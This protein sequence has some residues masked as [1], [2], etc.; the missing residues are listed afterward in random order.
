M[1]RITYLMF[2]TVMVVTLFFVMGCV[3]PPEVVEEP[4]VMEEEV[5]ME[6]QIV[7]IRND[8]FHPETL[9]IKGG[10]TVIFVNKD[11]IT[12]WPASDV[13]PLHTV[14]P[15]SGIYKCNTPE[16]TKIFDA[17]RRLTQGV[18]Y[19]FTF[20]EIGEWSYHDHTRP[21]LTGK[22]IVEE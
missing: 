6:A 10:D 19:S 21:S 18:E 20:N 12:H 3:P 8:G 17:C 14:Y 1:K 11:T 4:S 22:I 5:L 7:E 16:Q 13:H 15:G 2:L 9:T